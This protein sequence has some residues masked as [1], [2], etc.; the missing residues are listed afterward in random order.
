MAIREN[1]N[2]LNSSDVRVFPCAYRK[3][4][5]DAKA[6]LNLEENFKAL[7]ANGLG[8]RTDGSYVISKDSS[9]L[10]VVLGG[11]YFELP[12]NIADKYVFIITAVT[13]DNYRI[14]SSLDTSVVSLGDT[15]DN[16]GTFY[17]LGTTNTDPETFS[18]IDHATAKEIVHYV[19]IDNYEDYLPEIQHDTTTNSLILGSTTFTGSL[20]GSNPIDLSFPTI[21]TSNISVGSTITAPDIY[22]Q[23]L[24][25]WSS[26]YIRLNDS[27]IPQTCGPTNLLTNLGGYDI[28]LDYYAHFNT[29][30]ASNICLQHSIDGNGNY[31]IGL[32]YDPA[33]ISGFGCN[34]YYSD[35]LNQHNGVL[36]I[37][38]FNRLSV[39]GDTY[40]NIDGTVTFYSTLYANTIN[41]RSNSIW[42]LYNTSDI[43]IIAAGTNKSINLS[44]S[45]IYLTAP[46]VTLNTRSIYAGN[47][48]GD[49]HEI[50]FD[51]YVSSGHLSATTKIYLDSEY[52]GNDLYIN[53]LTNNGGISLRASRITLNAPTTSI[54]FGTGG[55]GGANLPIYID[56]SGY[57]KPC[58]CDVTSGAVTVSYTSFDV[59]RKKYGTST[60]SGTVDPGEAKV[61]FIKIGKQLTLHVRIENW[62]AYGSGSEFYEVKF[63]L[64][65][66]I[67]NLGLGDQ[68][69]PRGTS[70]IM[71]N[72]TPRGNDHTPNT[73]PSRI[74]YEVATTQGAEHTIYLMP[75]A[76]WAN[77][78]GA[79]SSEIEDEFTYIDLT[80]SVNIQ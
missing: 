62:G 2:L 19:R 75:T 16:N 42:K 8:K 15:L 4:T 55:V 14:L 38:G 28:D 56:S 39:L 53:R 59:Q 69:I 5:I 76:K 18:D 45:S 21:N 1:A 70:L 57:A 52:P 48:L 27:F 7:G 40:V 37:T 44:A 78:T 77:G 11:Y 17:G 35:S 3:P 47:P 13:T 73:F 54:K 36:D 66:L 33:I 68:T 74:K 64:D 23:N 30:Y 34:L 63:R 49:Y 60:W 24:A 31:S 71:V 51:G 12:A 67:S 65:K 72:A 43:S 61:N 58:S 20:Y 50:I 80:I 6:R 32:K 26:S 9:T 22:C 10:K 41:G 29:I 25:A 46:S 79:Y